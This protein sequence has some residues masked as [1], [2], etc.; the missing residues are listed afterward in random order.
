VTP[1]WLALPAWIGAAALGALVERIASGRVA[2]SALAIVT[3]ITQG[4]ALVVALAVHPL[5]G[6]AALGAMLA[7]ARRWP[8]S[9]PPARSLLALAW[10]AVVISV[11]AIQPP[12]PIA[13]DELVWLARARV[14]SGGPSVLV[15]RGLDPGGGLV[16]SGYPIGAGVLQSLMACLDD[17]LNA[18]TGGT[19]ALVAFSCA[20]FALALAQTPVVS[21][22]VAALVLVTTPLAWVH[23][24]TGMLD[25]P[26]GMLA[27]AFA[28]SVHGAGRGDAGLARLGPAIA[29]LLAALK[30]EGAMYVVVI[31]ATSLLDRSQRRSM[32]PHA[33]AGAAAAL[34][35]VIGWRARLALSGTAAEHHALVGLALGSVGALLAELVR[36]ASDL[37]SF[38]GSLAMV[39]VTVAV[40]L[41]P[42]SPPFVRA[43]ALAWIGC[44]AGTFAALLVGPDAVRSFAV[45]GTLWPRLLVQLMPLGTVLVGA[46]WHRMPSPGPA[47]GRDAT[48]APPR[49]ASPA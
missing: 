30:D 10:L 33:M 5:L 12:I 2:P 18:L 1:I 35:I 32:L 31:A 15:A 27:G 28:L 38:G 49:L 39:V 23:L 29:L 45:S 14:G 34:S 37:A 11:I 20:V 43:L 7:W 17:D 47:T 19:G 3:W 40:S 8:L 9:G 16:P 25:L 24:R 46:R 22:R 41:G 4:L 36:A 44:I 13:W 21:R 6:L 42:R 48:P 26:V